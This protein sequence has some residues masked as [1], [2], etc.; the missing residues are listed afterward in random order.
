[1]HV[2]LPCNLSLFH[3]KLATVFCCRNHR[4]C[5]TMKAKHMHPTT[6]YIREDGFFIM[7]ILKWKFGQDD[8]RIPETCTIFLTNIL[9]YPSW[10][11][12]VNDAQTYC[13]RHK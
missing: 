3:L 4:L 7:R 6:F 1:M 11:G 10:P 12:F 13:T 9:S 8:A 5:N 2:L